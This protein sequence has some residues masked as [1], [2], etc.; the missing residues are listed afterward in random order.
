MC[1]GVEERTFAGAT[2]ATPTCC[3]LHEALTVSRHG[4]LQVQRARFSMFA[5]RSNHESASTEPFQARHGRFVDLAPLSPPHQP[6]SPPL[7]KP[8]THY[9]TLALAS[10]AQNS[11]GPASAR[12]V[13]V[14]TEPRRREALRPPSNVVDSTKPRPIGT[15]DVRELLSRQMRT[16]E[17]GVWGGLQG[18]SSSVHD[19]FS[20]FF[21]ASCF[22][23][24]P[25]LWFV[26]PVVAGSYLPSQLARPQLHPGNAASPVPSYHPCS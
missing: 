12:S 19:F 22:P 4:P 8:T 6:V 25:R 5:S 20:F 7:M 14:G 17:L 26:Q 16:R 3:T 21:F 23:R 11:N 13:K 2:L 18:G 10:H 1:V 9:K 15:A 24:F